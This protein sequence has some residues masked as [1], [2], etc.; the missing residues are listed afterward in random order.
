[1][2]LD[3]GRADEALKYA[4]EAVNL[5]KGHEATTLVTAAWLAKGQPEE[6]LRAAMKEMQKCRLLRNSAGEATLMLDASEAYAAMGRGEDA[7]AAAGEARNVFREQGDATSELKA[8]QKAV[9]ANICMQNFLDALRSADEA[10]ALAAL[11]DDEQ[12]KAEAW[13]SVAK[14]RLHNKK[15]EGSMAAA[16]EALV[17][18]VQ[19]KDQGKQGLAHLVIAEAQITKE[20]SDEALDAALS[21][22][23][24]FE[25]CGKVLDATKAL[26]MIIGCHIASGDKRGALRAAKDALA[27]SKGGH[28]ERAALFMVFDT[29]IKTEDLKGAV[30]MGK[31]AMAR[32]AEVQ[33]TTGK[34]DMALK[35]ARVC[36]QQG[37]YDEATRLAHKAQAQ[38]EEN[39]NVLKE[40]AALQLLTDIQSSRNNMASSAKRQE[41][42][43]LVRELASAAER[44]NIQDWRKAIKKLES[45]Q[46]I[47]QEDLDEAL[48]P[49]FKKDADGAK[50]FLAEYADEV[51]AAPGYCDQYLA[52]MDGAGM[53]TP[54][55]MR[56]MDK[57]MHYYYHRLGGMGFGPRFRT[58]DLNFKVC[59]Q[60]I[61]G[62]V[63]TAQLQ[64]DGA[65][66]W[67]EKLG[68]N[69][70]GFIDGG[71]HSGMIMGV[72]QD[73]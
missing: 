55:K 12:A 26:D 27:A 16:N 39:G 63:A 40:Q 61:P 6:A 51:G 21:A 42:L 5:G 66:A 56:G 47:I 23:Q 8:L 60:D 54:M 1:M 37:D 57:T 33:D 38:C 65:D 67:E 49:I 17:R 50:A 72:V 34:V 58:V 11:G 73:D 25:S 28:G 32:L 9:H 53:G 46:A 14:A 24:K 64:L 15:P 10:L 20:R 30:E 52:T 36:T 69:Y 41:G 68:S 3:K 45:S 59:N 2:S 13:L 19:Y 44:K 35:V 31:D 4:T 43:T 29:Y 71:L 22:L 18:Y 7:V 70:P 48:V 62:Y